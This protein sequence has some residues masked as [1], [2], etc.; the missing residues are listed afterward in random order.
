MLQKI[1]EWHEAHKEDSEELFNSGDWMVHPTPPE[2]ELAQ[3]YGI[4][5]ESAIE[6][7]NEV[8]IK[9]ELE[10][11]IYII[12][13]NQTDSEGDPFDQVMDNLGGKGYLEGHGVGGRFY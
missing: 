7:F 4:Q 1:A 8:T 3:Q 12:S 6:W 11:Y 5:W 9:I 2:L 10:R 13:P